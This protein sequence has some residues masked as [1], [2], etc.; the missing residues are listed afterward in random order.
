YE[1]MAGFMS[2][3]IRRE[4]QEQGVQLDLERLFRRLDYTQ[5]GGAPL[6]GVNGVTII[7]HGGSPPLAIRNALRKAASSVA[8]GMVE[9]VAGRLTRPGAATPAP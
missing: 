6:L 4:I 5:W 7:C 8:S 3:F 2:G 1:S 9:H